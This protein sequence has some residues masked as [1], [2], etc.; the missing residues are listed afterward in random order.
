MGICQ[1]GMLP[2]PSGEEQ[3]TTLGSELRQ[4]RCLPLGISSL[5]KTPKIIFGLA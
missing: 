3:G 5:G 1:A 2:D 4:R